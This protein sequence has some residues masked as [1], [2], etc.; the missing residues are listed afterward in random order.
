[1]EARCEVRV[2][3]VYLKKV[4][5]THQFLNMFPKMEENKIPTFQRFGKPVVTPSTGGSLNRHVHV[6]DYTVPSGNSGPECPRETWLFVDARL[7]GTPSAQRGCAR[8]FLRHELYV[9][10]QN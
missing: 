1:M 4:T 2:S 10:R 9:V 5:V 8:A 7:P 6:P 3:G